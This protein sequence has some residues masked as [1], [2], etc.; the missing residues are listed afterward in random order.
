MVLARP[1]RSECVGRHAQRR[2]GPRRVEDLH[3]L[4]VRLV[5]SPRPARPG[6]GDV[7]ERLGQL[8]DR[9][10]DAGAD[11]Q[12]VLQIVVDLGRLEDGVG[13]VLDVEELADRPAGAPEPTSDALARFGL[14]ELAHQRRD[15]VRAMGVVGVPRAVE[16]RQ[17]QVDRVEAVLRLVGAAL[18]RH[19]LLGQAVV[20]D[21]AVQGPAQRSSSRIRFSSLPGYEQAVPTTTNLPIVSTCRAASNR[22]APII[23]LR[24]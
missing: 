10:A 21:A 13:A 4:P 15:D 3:R 24:K 8:L 16:V 12:R 1:S 5:A 6:T 17:H 23:R 22:L 14:D 20:L 2:A 18:H 9:G 7:A 11:V 19:D